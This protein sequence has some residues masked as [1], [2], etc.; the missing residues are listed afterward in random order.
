M[1]KSS[2]SEGFELLNK[3][4]SLLAKIFSYI[5]EDTK[6]LAELRLVS[7]EWNTNVRP[8]VFRD[9]GFRKVWYPTKH[10]YCRELVQ[11]DDSSFAGRYY[12]PGSFDFK[13]FVSPKDLAKRREKIDFNDEEQDLG[14]DNWK[15]KALWAT[16]EGI[17]FCRDDEDWDWTRKR[18]IRIEKA[19]S[20][21][22]LKD[23]SSRFALYCER[24]SS[25]K[26][27]DDFKTLVDDAIADGLFLCLEDLTNFRRN[28]EMIEI[29]QDQ[30]ENQEGLPRPLIVNLRLPKKHGLEVIEVDRSKIVFLKV[31]IDMDSDD[32]TDAEHAFPFVEDRRRSVLR[33]FLHSL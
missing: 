14:R 12:E 4:S 23:D 28:G 25:T 19:E 13:F 7:K 11:I 29:F 1:K 17:L 9:F 10:N 20:Y 27:I 6:G 18:K 16:T 33:G 24:I 15:P 31:E 5:I 8:K 32:T 3:H 22:F 30:D 26:S 2:S 21:D